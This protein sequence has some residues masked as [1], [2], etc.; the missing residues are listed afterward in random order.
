[1]T[2][3]RNGPSIIERGGR[4]LDAIGFDAYNQAV[5]GDVAKSLTAVKSDADHTPVVAVPYTLKIRGGVEVDSAGKA[6]GKGALIQTNLSA[7][8]GTSQDQE[9]FE[10]KPVVYAVDQGGGKSGANV[11]EDTAP[12]LCT[13]HG[14]EPAVA[15]A[16]QGFGDYKE[17]ETAS[18]CKA[19]DYKD[20][21]DLVAGVDCRNMNEYP[22]LYPT[23]Q[24]NLD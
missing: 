11:S 2:A 20:S 15:F 6:A 24:N 8:L 7:T 22:E 17:S 12:T 3:T 10:P 1:M 14:G 16:M 23:L 13:T 21:T 4:Q 5:T 18:A 9:L 19:R